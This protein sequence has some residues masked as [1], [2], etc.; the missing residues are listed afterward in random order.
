MSRRPTHFRAD[1]VGEFSGFTTRQGFPG[2]TGESKAPFDSFNLG[3]GL[4]D[5]PEA[6]LANRS[7]LARQVGVHQDKLFFMDQVHGSDI[8]EVVLSGAVS[9]PQADAMVSAAMGLGLAVLVADCVPILMADRVAKVIG[10]AHAGRKGAAAGIA[11][12]LVS[13]MVE[14]GA[15]VSKVKVAVGPAICGRCYE[16]PLLMQLEV[17]SLLPGS[18]CSTLGGTPGLDLRAGVVRAL[19]TVGVA[20]RNIIVDPRCTRADGDLFSYR[21]SVHTGRFA[22]VIT[23]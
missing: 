10:V 1:G 13:R 3:A 21:R 2:F 20:A 4:A 17:E 6:V 7:E 12:A 23:Q 14:L 11:P 18:A 16:V 22:G 9:V 5:A 19:I 8:A 15:T